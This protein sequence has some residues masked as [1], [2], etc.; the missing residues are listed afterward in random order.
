MTFAPSDDVEPASVTSQTSAITD[1]L[2]LTSLDSNQVPYHLLDQSTDSNS[3]SFDRGSYGD[4][5]DTE[6]LLMSKC[7][8]LEGVAGARVRRFY[9]HGFWN[10]E[11]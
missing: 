2:S 9:C 1:N 8:R 5:S 4:R 3:I 11:V 10:F 7:L 6:V